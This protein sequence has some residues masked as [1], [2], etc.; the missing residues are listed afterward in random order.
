[1]QY[2]LKST[3]TNAYVQKTFGVTINHLTVQN[4]DTAQTV[5]LSFDGATQAGEL[6]AGESVTMNVTGKSS[7]YIKSDTSPNDGTF[8]F[9]GW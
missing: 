9:W 8:R 4:K 1:M 5:S 2:F 7:I 6:S 3:C